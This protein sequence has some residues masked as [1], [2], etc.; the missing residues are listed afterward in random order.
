[1]TT[2]RIA[3]AGADVTLLLW[4]PA[5]EHQPDGEVHAVSD[6]TVLYDLSLPTCRDII[7]KWITCQP[8]IVN[9]LREFESCIDNHLV[10][11]MIHYALVQSTIYTNTSSCR[12]FILDAKEMNWHNDIL[13]SLA[14]CLI[15]D[16]VFKSFVQLL[17]QRQ[18]RLQP[19]DLRPPAIKLL[20][21]RTRFKFVLQVHRFTA[22]AVSHR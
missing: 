2:N 18:E 22:F 6:F 5:V 11:D 15:C 16:Q 8:E 17:L 21:E 10:R 4:D 1:M 20:S 13:F 12:V 14:V 3:D 19:S 7:Q 9:N